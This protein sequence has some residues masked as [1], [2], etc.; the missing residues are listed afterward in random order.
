MINQMSPINE[1]IRRIVISGAIREDTAFQFLEQ[2]TA[3]EYLDIT[4]PITIYIDS[5][6]GNLD[7]AFMIYDAIRM[8]NCP[9]TTVGI[10]KVMSAGSLILASGDPGFRFLTKNTRVMVHPVSG[11]VMGDLGEMNI[12]IEEVNK[13]QDMYSSL[14]AQHTGRTKKQVAEDMKRTIYMSAPEAI[15]YGLADKVLPFKKIIIPKNKKP[16]KNVGKKIK[17]KQK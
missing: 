6:G 10:G 15:K 9:I 5:Y 13:L 16:L 17:K 8:C 4:K 12:E 3:L 1:I 2:L 14:I 11:R 7:S